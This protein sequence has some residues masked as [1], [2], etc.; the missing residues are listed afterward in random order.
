[1]PAPGRR[2]MFKFKFMF[3]HTLARRWDATAT[4]FLYLR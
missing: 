2:F 3:K 1:M 4:A